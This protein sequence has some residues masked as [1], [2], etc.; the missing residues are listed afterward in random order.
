MGRT[1]EV[2]A[3]LAGDTSIT[4]AELEARANR[5]AHHLRAN[6]VGPEVVVG[7]CLVRGL[8]MVVALLAVLKAGGTYLPLDPSYPADRLSLMLEDSA[9][10]VV[11]TQ[12][13]LLGRLP[14][15]DAEVVCV[16]Q[17]RSLVAG[18]PAAPPGGD[19]DAG[20]VAYL[21]YTSGSTGRPKG[22]QVPHR[23]MVNFLTTM[24]DRPGIGPA[25]VLVA[26]TTLSFDIAGLELFLPLTVGARVVVAPADVANAPGPLIQL[27]VASGATVMQA[28]PATWRMLV[29]AGWTGGGALKV[30]CGG[31]ALPV[32]LAGEL[33]RRGVQLWNMYGPTETTVW[34]TTRQVESPGQATNIGRPIANTTV[35]ILD[36][37]L[38]P[39]AV[40]EAG[41]LH[42]GGAGMA[43]GYLR[44]PELTAERFIDHPFDTTPGARVYKTGDL[45]R[46]AP[47]GTI[48][49]L[50]R[51]DHQV[52][53]RGFRIELG[54]IETALEAQAGVRAA[55][56]TA[57]IDPSGGSRLVA[58]LVPEPPAPT[59]GELRHTLS[60]KLPSHM[61]PSSFV[62]LDALPL[63]PAGKVDRKALPEPGASRPDVLSAFV[64]PRTEIERK[65][66]KIWSE[67]L[68]VDEVGAEDDFFELGGH[69]LAAVLV[70]SRIRELVGAELTLR[71]IY[72]AP[73]LA[74]LATVVAASEGREDGPQL[75]A[76]DRS[77]FVR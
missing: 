22:V 46:W 10:P 17:E 62:T 71:A 7:I 36:A 20:Q 5:L 67:A 47:D 61:V 75:V 19:F 29:D 31:E 72:D 73:T 55:V 50:G 39:V 77:T 11:V 42:I 63:N 3:V 49:F 2:T 69:S 9:A 1:P 65:L 38:A 18:Q 45:V 21:I 43:K 13:S 25:D 74:E 35:Y 44:R 28:T 48:E 4:Y 52:K 16:D 76:L 37:A 41:E 24:A 26:V 56:V 70:V 40:G 34:S 64:A 51:L 60:Q 33:V 15:H 66:A 68:G 32:A 30:L 8:E 57:A 6:G 53:I 59:V 58:Y 27:M 54:E 12:S 23:A 14:A